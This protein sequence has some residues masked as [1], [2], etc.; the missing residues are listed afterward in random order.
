MGRHLTYQGN[1]SP[2]AEL[3]RGVD[4]DTSEHDG[5]WSSQCVLTIILCVLGRVFPRLTVH[6]FFQFWTPPLGRTLTSQED[7]CPRAGFVPADFVCPAFWRSAELRA[8]RPRVWIARSGLG[9][10]VV[11]VTPRAVSPRPDI[12]REAF[13]DSHMCVSIRPSECVRTCVCAGP[14]VRRG[15]AGS[16][17]RHLCFLLCWSGMQGCFLYPTSHVLEGV[18]FWRDFPKFPVFRASIIR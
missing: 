18:A 14:W 10:S 13:L 11:A 15:I 3:S 6:L 9:S 17:I 8:R 4:F 7:R 16:D 5:S 2:K 1:R 12:L